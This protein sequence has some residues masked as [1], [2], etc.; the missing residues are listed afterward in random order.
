MTN[1]FGSAVTDGSSKGTRQDR[2]P[3]RRAER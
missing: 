1:G 2:N 3:D